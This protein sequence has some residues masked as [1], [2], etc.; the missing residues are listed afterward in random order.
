MGGASLEPGEQV[1]VKEKNIIQIYTYGADRKFSLEKE[2]TT[3]PTNVE[4]DILHG[5]D[6]LESLSLQSLLD[7]TREIIDE[8]KR[9]TQE[10][11]Q[12]QIE[13]EEQK[14]SVISQDLLKKYA[15]HIKILEQSALEKSREAKYKK[16]IQESKRDFVYPEIDPETD[17][18]ISKQ[19]K[20][21][22][23][24]ET[25]DT[26][27]E[28]NRDG[29]LKVRRQMDVKEKPLSL[30]NTDYAKKYAFFIQVIQE[31]FE[32]E[33][34]NED[35]EKGFQVCSILEGQIPK[36]R[37]IKQKQ[38]NTYIVCIFATALVFIFQTSASPYNVNNAIG[39]C[40]FTQRGYPLDIA[41]ENDPSAGIIKSL[42]CFLKT[43]RIQIN[44][45]N[46]ENSK[47]LDYVKP[48]VEVFEKTI[49]KYVTAVLSANPQLRNALKKRQQDE[50]RKQEMVKYSPFNVY[51]VERDENPQLRPVPDFSTLSLADKR[52]YITNEANILL[53]ANAILRDI[54]KRQDPILV[55]SKGSP[56]I[57]NS[58]SYYRG[59]Q[60]ETL[61]EVLNEKLRPLLLSLRNQSFMRFDGS[62]YYT[63]EEKALETQKR[64]PD[65]RLPIEAIMR[66]AKKSNPGADL[67]NVDFDR[68]FFQGLLKEL[69]LRNLLPAPVYLE[70]QEITSLGQPG[71]M[72]EPEK[73]ELYSNLI[74]QM[75]EIAGNTM[76]D[77]RDDYVI[78]ERAIPDVFNSVVKSVFEIYMPRIITNKKQPTEEIKNMK[79]NEF[80]NHVFKGKRLA[81]EH[82]QS[83]EL[84]LRG[85]DLTDFYKILDDFQGE[86]RQQIVDV[87]RNLQFPIEI[88]SL[89]F[90]KIV[91]DFLSDL[92]EDS[93]VKD[94]SIRLIL[95]GIKLVLKMMNILAKTKEELEEYMSSIVERERNMIISQDDKLKDDNDKRQL[96]KVQK[97]L[98]LGVWALGAR[99]GWDYTAELYEMEVQQ[100]KEWEAL[101]QQAHGG[102]VNVGAGNFTPDMLDARDNAREDARVEAEELQFQGAAE[103]D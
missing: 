61:S 41:D 93:D 47:D 63:L 73:Q 96:N 83:I 14:I 46:A 21:P 3:K 28:Y 92:E 78:T 11:R 77:F 43:L 91:T 15:R 16:S 99:K 35:I 100:L 40:S 1:I 55:N 12:L 102:D 24:V 95:E 18:Y 8:D 103:E 52:E 53:T 89:D 57:G 13:Y 9:V 70:E 25:L 26:T 94:L 71:D 10:L 75:G 79:D 20:E 48:K 39:K 80:M 67:S 31:I 54:I 66:L 86:E 23:D 22:V 36:G 56:Y 58:V 87:F 27:D 44:Q 69:R 101:Q 65:Y 84:I 60:S 76:E 34:S 4:Q 50:R 98:K 37:K 64:E 19:E 49:Y 17:F 5:E 62:L 81:R 74:E 38:K 68:R 51:P 85:R 2:T 97:A 42:A 33:F 7:K 45:K 82:R 90:V 32:V 29:S 88:T 30:P 59:K 6:D 72:G